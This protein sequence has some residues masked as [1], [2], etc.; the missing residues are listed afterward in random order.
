VALG[1]DYAGNY[2]SLITTGNRCR[3]LLNLD[4]AQ[5][6][7][8]KCGNI[9]VVGAAR[10]GGPSSDSGPVLRIHTSFHLDPDP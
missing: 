2:E 3:N 5:N 9:S 6:L 7:A 8:K 1:A 4:S 10:F